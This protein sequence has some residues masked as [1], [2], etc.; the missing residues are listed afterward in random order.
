MEQEEE[1]QEGQ[2]WKRCRGIR[3]LLRRPLLLV[4][5]L[6]L[7]A[8]AVDVVLA[9][10]A[11][12]SYLCWDWDWNSGQD[13]WLMLCFDGDGDDD[14]GDPVEESGVRAAVGPAGH[15]VRQEM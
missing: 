5:L 11:R 4:L 10:D 6:L 9:L 15:D 3:L 12:S 14:C 1:E 13:G 8:G 2:R 7:L